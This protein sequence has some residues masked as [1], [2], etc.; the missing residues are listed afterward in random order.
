[1]RGWSGATA[2]DMRSRASAGSSRSSAS[3][4]SVTL[5]RDLIC[6]SRR[7]NCSQLVALRR[8]SVCACST[9]PCHIMSQT[10]R[11]LR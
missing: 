4:A 1:M 5:V 2:T 11:S 9:C 3:S 7:P 8:A 10:R 6:S